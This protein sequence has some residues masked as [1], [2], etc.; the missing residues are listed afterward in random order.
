M[1]KK[2]KVGDAVVPTKDTVKKWKDDITEGKVY[3]VSRHPMFNDVCVFDDSGTCYWT[4]LHQ[5]FTK[6]CIEPKYVN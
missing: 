2:F 4:T 6:V 1:F 5:H 3:Y